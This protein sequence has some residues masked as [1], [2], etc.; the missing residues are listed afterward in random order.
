MGIPTMPKKT[1]VPV[2]ASNGAGY[3][4]ISATIFAGYV[5][6]QEMPL[7][8]TYSGSFTAQ[9]LTYK[10][11]DDNYTAIYALTPGTILQLG[12]SIN[13]NR[14]IGTVKLT[15]PDGSSRTTPYLKVQ[16]ATTTATQVEVR[17][18]PQNATR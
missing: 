7:G 14:S 6:I 16:S 18:F 12:D 4:L 10:L 2:N 3:V 15:F 17:E 8:S 9:G 13:K 1:V 11:P 5:E